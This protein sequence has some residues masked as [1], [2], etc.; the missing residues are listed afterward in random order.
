MK[1]RFCPWLSILNIHLRHKKCS[2]IEASSLGISA[3]SLPCFVILLLP[4]T[5][6]PVQSTANIQRLLHKEEEEEEQVTVEKVKL[7]R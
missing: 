6:F 5:G 3:S 7:Q 2:R 4:L 1:C